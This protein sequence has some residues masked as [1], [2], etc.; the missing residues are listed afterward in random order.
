MAYVYKMDKDSDPSKMT[1]TAAVL[2]DVLLDSGLRELCRDPESGLYPTEDCVFTYIG[3]YNS[4][5]MNPY[6]HYSYDHSLFT[7]CNLTVKAGDE[8]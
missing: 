1:L 6:Q 4:S 7:K 2:W 5:V 3:E 8:Q